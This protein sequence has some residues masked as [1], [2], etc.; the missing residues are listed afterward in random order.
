[1]DLR[2]TFCQTMFAISRDD[3]LAALEHLEEHH[4]TYYDAHCPQ[5]RRANRV[6]RFKLELSYPNWREV[7]AA[8]AKEAPAAAPIVTETPAPVSAPV[9]TPEPEPAAAPARHH[10][11]SHKPAATVAVTPVVE[12][13]AA[14]AP[15]ATSSPMGK[16][17]AQAAAKPVT[18]KAAAKPAPKK[19]STKP[20]AK[21]PAAP[22]KGKKTT[23]GAK[24][25]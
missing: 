12:K 11:H 7:I 5:C 21:K 8:K 19:T 16:T 25:K 22:A 6:E 17:A 14:P 2:C 20:A 15:K 9:S 24:K 1:M 3:T 13:K 4:Q 23:S 10:K 18:K